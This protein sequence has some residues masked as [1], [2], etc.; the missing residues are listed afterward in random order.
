MVLF[1]ILCSE[2]AIIDSETSSIYFAFKRTLVH[3]IVDTIN[4]NNNVN[5]SVSRF[6]VVPRAKMKI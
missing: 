1:I 5:V 3:F 6:K 2:D 4:A